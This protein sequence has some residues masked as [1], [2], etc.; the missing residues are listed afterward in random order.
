MEKPTEETSGVP[1][2]VLPANFFDN[3]LEGMVAA[4][5]KQKQAERELKEWDLFPIVYF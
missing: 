1:K 4:G 5:T 3:Q 2:G